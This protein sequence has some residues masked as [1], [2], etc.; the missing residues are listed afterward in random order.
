MTEFKDAVTTPPGDDEPADEVEKKDK[1]EERKGFNDEIEESI[2][3]TLDWSNCRVHK[4]L[5]EEKQK[6]VEGSD[7]NQLKQ[8]VAKLIEK[9]DNLQ[10][11]VSILSEHLD[12]LEKSMEI[13]LQGVV[14]MF[15]TLKLEIEQLKAQPVEEHKKDKELPELI[16]EDIADD[17]TD[18]SDTL[19][20]CRTDGTVVRVRDDGP[21]VRIRDDICQKTEP[22]KETHVE[23]KTEPEHVSE[24]KYEEPLIVDE[25]Q[26]FVNV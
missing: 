22:E 19:D 6:M 13:R 14:G 11:N 17:I 23:P 10:L 20:I 18:D 8:L 2:R 4:E 21:V 12:N 15:D 5:G 9:T 25:R 24:K 26:K 3:T 7:I 1:E 16:D